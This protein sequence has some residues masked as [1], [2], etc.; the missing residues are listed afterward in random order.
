MSQLESAFIFD[1]IRTPRGRGKPSGSLHSQ[2]PLGLTT[3]LLSELQRRFPGIENYEPEVILGCC[4]QYS[5]QGGNLARSAA[6][7]AGYSTGT[8]GFMVSRFCGSAL[9]AVNVG[10]TKLMAGQGDLVIAGGIEMLSLFTIFGSGGPLI[11]DVSF[12]DRIV[13]IPQ[14]LSA[15]LIATRQGY[16]RADVDALAAS[17]QQRASLAWRKGW[18]QHSVISV[19]RP[20]EESVQRDELVR[21]N[22]TAASL[23]KLAPAFQKAGEEDG[24]SKIVR[25]RYP[26]VGTINYVHHAG[27]SSG[28]ADGAAVVLIGS[29]EAG[30]QLGLRPRARI[31]ATAAAADDPCIMLTAPAPAAQRAL[32]RA[33]LRSSDIDLY[34]VNEAFASVVLYFMEKTKT[35]WEK[36]NVAGGSIAMGHPVGAT[37]AM[38]LGTLLDELERRDLSTGLITMCTGLGMGVATVIERVA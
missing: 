7:N 33:K 2:T 11:S 18:F 19:P 10:A 17:S 8:P 36:I 14:G 25:F 16:S 12:K 20:G 23:A 30:A 6:L 24:Y 34:E 3:L 38:L 37:G 15:D 9:D 28:I 32:E 35:P 26:E 13:S 29:G 22:V 27:N 4:E 21:N 5:D 1:A 31:L